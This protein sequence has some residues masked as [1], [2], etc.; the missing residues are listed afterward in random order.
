MCY[1]IL[2]DE[3]CIENIKKLYLFE[4]IYFL[5]YVFL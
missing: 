1:R 5:E 2:I 3:K 4:T